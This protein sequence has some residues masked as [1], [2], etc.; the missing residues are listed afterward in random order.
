M[1]VGGGVET[2]PRDG[3]LGWGRGLTEAEVVLGLLEPPPPPPPPVPSATASSVSAALLLVVVPSGSFP[4]G[5]GPADEDVGAAKAE[6]STLPPPP[7]PPLPLPPPLPFPPSRLR[8]SS[9][10]RS[11]L[12]HFARRFW[13]HTWK[14]AA[15]RI[16]INLMIKLRRIDNG[17]RNF[18]AEV[19][20]LWAKLLK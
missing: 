17:K 3:W 19:S 7:P 1:G 4:V 6:D 20:V 16:D 15:V 13:N 14:S 12:R 11:L 8:C 2:P 9:F 10:N 18:D 5:L